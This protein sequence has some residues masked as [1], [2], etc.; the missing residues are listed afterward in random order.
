MIKT[1]DQLSISKKRVFIRVDFNVSVDENEKVVD[2]TRIRAVLPTIQHA[3]AQE[4]KVILAS[5]LGRPKGM[6]NPKFSLL[7]VAAH[8]SKLLGKD[9][10]FPEDC[11][12]D[13]VKKLTLDMR[14]GDVILLENLRFHAEEEKNDPIFAERLSS[15]ADVYVNDAFGTLHRTHSST[16]GMVKHFQEKGMGYLVQKEVDYLTRVLDQPERPLLAI[17]GGSKVADKLGVVE[18]LLTKVDALLIGGAMSYTFLKA[19]GVEV[20][21]SLVEEG[22]VHL[23]AKFLERAKLKGIPL[24]LPVDHRIAEKIS[25]QTPSQILKENPPSRIAEGNIPKGFMGLDIGP[26][27]VEIFSKEIAKARTV[28][29]N[30][31]MGVYEYPPFNAGTLAMA[32]AVA[33]SEG[34]TVVGGGDSAAAVMEAGVADKIRHIST[35]GGAT[36]ACLEGKTLP[37]LKALEY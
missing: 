14:E 37:G 36:L 17:L 9:V 23:A 35:G 32:Q 24:L 27:T 4:A 8:L 7:P 18:Y 19:T 12:G 28:I 11:I 20:G 15:L 22:K 34:L 25:D 3:L 29:W 2:D 30:G 13:A 10:I 6:K 31:P 33:K 5:H 26:K 1:M 16:V 21:D